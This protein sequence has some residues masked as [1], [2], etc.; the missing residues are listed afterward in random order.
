V[1]ALGA[2]LFI[3]WPSGVYAANLDE[4]SKYLAFL[5]GFQHLVE[6]CP[7]EAKLPDNEVNYARPCKEDFFSG[8][9]DAEKR[10]DEKELAAIRKA[11]N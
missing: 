1:F 2:P 6:F 5:D 8:V 4:L 7:A 10:A 9:V 11:K 3:G